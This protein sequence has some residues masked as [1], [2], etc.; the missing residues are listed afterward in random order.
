MR[1]RGFKIIG[2]IL[3]G[4]VI[5]LLALK[6]S[7][8]SDFRNEASELTAGE[9]VATQTA[10]TQISPHDRDPNRLWCNEHN[11]YEDECLICHPELAAKTENKTARLMC[12]EH[13]VYEDE[14]GICHP[15][16]LDNLEPGQGLKIRLESSESS[17][18]AGIN[19]TLPVTGHSSSEIVLLSRVE[20]NQNKFA[21]ITPLAAGVVQQV[22]A[23]PGDFI[24]ESKVL[25]EIISP[26]ISGAKSDYVS[27]LAS[28]VLK[29]LAFKREKELV[30]QKITSRQ[31]YEQAMAEYQIAQNMTKMS[32]QRLL[33]YGLSEEQIKEV[34]ETNSSSSTFSVKAP[35]SGTIIDRRAVMGEAVTSGDILFTLADLSA[36]WLELS[37]PEDRLSQMRA[38]VPI[39]AHFDALPNLAVRG[40]IIWLA[41]NIDDQTR[42]LKA[43]AVVPNPDL[44]LKHN[45]F[46]EVRILADQTSA[47]LH[48]PIEALHSFNGDNVVFVKLTNDLYEIRKVLLGAKDKVRA[49]ITN[50]LLPQEQ[51]VTTHSF[52]LKSEF[53][54]SRLGAGCVDE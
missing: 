21:R 41:S 50:G 4:G 7:S 15:E 12:E 48:I 39:E 23:D 42:M 24:A 53:L 49:E 40:R 46:G 1:S 37:I 26:E 45:M 5:A 3:A 43:R 44:I 16:L 18:I 52:T 38:D 10:N 29:E 17:G 36:M 9:R 54:K 35:F 32:K 51:V 27:A 34:A 2:L 13:Q 14:C 22:L 19:T 28:E 8:K 31:E 33:N 47:V 20:Y 6:L 25:A 11:V 30:D